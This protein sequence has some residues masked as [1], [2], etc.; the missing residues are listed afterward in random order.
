MQSHIPGLSTLEVKY[1]KRARAQLG[2]PFTAMDMND[3]ELDCIAEGVLE[4]GPDDAEIALITRDR[5]ERGYLTIGHIAAILN[6][7]V[8]QEPPAPKV[9][10]RPTRCAACHRRL[11]DVA[12]RRRGYGP[13][14][15]AKVRRG[16]AY[17]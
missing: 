9:R 3:P 2:R 16:V 15:W 17:G 1:V 7:I 8:A 14:C 12:S 6:W 10:P 13:G 4:A 11:T 5:D